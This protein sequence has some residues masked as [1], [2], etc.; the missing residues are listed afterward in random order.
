M[1]SVLIIHK[2]KF[3]IS[4]QHLTPKV[5]TEFDLNRLKFQIQLSGAAKVLYPVVAAYLVDIS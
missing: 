2:P 1:S 3:T 5:A 4:K